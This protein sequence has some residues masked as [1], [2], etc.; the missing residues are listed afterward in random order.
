MPDEVPSVT[1][2]NKAGD[3]IRQYLGGGVW[4]LEDMDPFFQAFDVLEVWRAAH[5]APLQVATM[6]LR[7]RV[8]TARCSAAT[9]VSQR[10]KRI[11]TIMSKLHREPGMELGRMADIGGCRA[12]VLDLDEVYRVLGR[13]QARNQ[14]EVVKVRDYIKNPKDDGY[15]AVHVIVRYHGRLIEVQLRTQVQHEWAYTVESVTSRFGLDIKSG[16]GP[17]PVRAWFQ[18]VSEAMAFEERGQVV[19]TD[20]L[21]RVHTLREEAQPYL[22]GGRS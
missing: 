10:L 13:Y 11:P 20:L 3:V 8:A 7:S 21:Q 16:G 2:V 15:R 18:A 14:P 17:P 4:S 9:R 19:D 5:A 22:Q 6:G 1:R 12:V